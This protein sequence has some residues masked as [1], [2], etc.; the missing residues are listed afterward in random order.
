VTLI[1][2]V[3]LAVVV[4]ATMPP[5][6]ASAFI[7]PAQIARDLGDQDASLSPLRLCTHCTA[8]PEMA[9]PPEHTLPLPSGA[10]RFMANS[11]PVTEEYLRLPFR[12]PMTA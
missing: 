3:L 9:A 8:E 4:D 6:V 5:P 1:R 11:A 2:L 10:H 12:P 7:E